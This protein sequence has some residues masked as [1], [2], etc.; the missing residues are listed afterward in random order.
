[1]K[2]LKIGNV[3]PIADPKRQG[4]TDRKENVAGPSFTEELQGSI[5]RMNELNIQN[6]ANLQAKDVKAADMT[7]EISKAREDFDQM[8]QVK[9]N[10]SRLYHDITK[11]EE[12]S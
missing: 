2:D 7:N 6:Q 9:Q 12:S 3:Q 5:A 8:M 11:S 4:K 1:M 10:L